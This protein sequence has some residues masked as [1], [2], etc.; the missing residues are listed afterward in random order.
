MKLSKGKR[1]SP[2]VLA[3]QV[4]HRGTVAAGSVSDGLVWV[5]MPVCG[6]RPAAGDGLCWTE[7]SSRFVKG[8]SLLAQRPNAR[9]RPLLKVDKVL[10][11]TKALVTD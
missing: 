2:V 9:T 8:V 11:N 7:D 1:L 5:K 4:L 3:V 10:A 6:S